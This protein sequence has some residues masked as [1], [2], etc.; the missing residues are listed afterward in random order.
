MAKIGVMGDA[1]SVMGFKTLGIDTFSVTDEEAPRMIHKLAR[2]KYAVIFI[3]EKTARL[4]S[5]AVSRY[6]NVAY[7][8]IIPIPGNYGTT[9][10][11]MAALKAN[12]EKAIG[13]DILFNAEDK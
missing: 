13:V 10:L 5:E 8:A 1:D 4:A 3:T 11:G 6:K 9:G 12:V 7:P 2:E